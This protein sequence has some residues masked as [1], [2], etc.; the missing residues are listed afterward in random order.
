MQQIRMSWRNGLPTGGANMNRRPSARPIPIQ[1]GRLAVHRTHSASVIL[2]LTPV[3]MI[4]QLRDLGSVSRHLSGNRDSP[5]T[6]PVAS[7]HPTA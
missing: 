6:L 3:R 4:S 5:F 7:P 1:I 2:I